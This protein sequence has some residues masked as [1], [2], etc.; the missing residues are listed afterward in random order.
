MRKEMIKTAVFAVSL[1]L[2]LASM[3]GIYTIL[4]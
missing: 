2:F 1:V 3:A 4:G